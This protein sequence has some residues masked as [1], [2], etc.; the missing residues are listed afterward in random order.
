MP[1]PT[2]RDIDGTLNALS[3]APE[4][5]LARE[6]LIAANRG[7]RAAASGALVPKV[8]GRAA[9]L[10]LGLHAIEAA[11]IASSPEV[12][13][14]RVEEAKGLAKQ[15][16]ARRL[17]AAYD[18]PVGLIYG[19]GALVKETRDT[20]DDP[21]LRAQDLAY[22]RWQADRD[23]AAARKAR[24]AGAQQRGRAAMMTQPHSASGT[25]QSVTSNSAASRFTQP[26]SLAAAGLRKA[27]IKRAA[28]TR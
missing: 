2:S 8:K 6:R 21:R 19:T 1:A 15:S 12:R 14:S 24:E 11:R 20:L 13:E 23:F 26:E 5:I 22:L 28:T 27:R 9:A 7:A 17:F 25:P 4:A 10:E 16:V 18:N 3:W